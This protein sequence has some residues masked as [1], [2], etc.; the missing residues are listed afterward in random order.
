MKAIYLY[1]ENETAV[2]RRVSILGEKR[3]LLE[4]LGVCEGARAKIF[5]KDHQKIILKLEK[6]KLALSRDIALNISAE[7][8]DPPPASTFK[9]SLQI[10]RT[11]K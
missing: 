1:E 11:R 8:A 6:T 2:I 3:A 7:P 10:S 5:M 9:E 4:S